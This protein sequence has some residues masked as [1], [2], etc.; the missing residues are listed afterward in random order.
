[1]ADFKLLHDQ[2]Y[3]VGQSWCFDA[4]WSLGSE[5]LKID[6]VR[7]AY[8]DQSHRRVLLLDRVNGRWNQLWELPFKTA[9]CHPIQYVQ[10]R[11]KV[12]GA[13]FIRDAQE[14]LAVAKKILED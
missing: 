9:H 8:D 2:M 7:N 11:E 14:L 12:N 13:L 5:R 6:I 10:P 3:P 1:M 4:L